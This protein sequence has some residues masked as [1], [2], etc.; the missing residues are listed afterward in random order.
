MI[1]FK[2]TVAVL[3]SECPIEEAETL[4]AWLVEHRAGRVNM[5]ALQHPH[6]AV[7]QVLMA[8]QPEITVWPA[9]PDVSAWVK[10]MMAQ[11]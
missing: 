5:K 8:A 6:T 2:K 4:L 7:M 3:G 11:N 9:N 10:P 1:E